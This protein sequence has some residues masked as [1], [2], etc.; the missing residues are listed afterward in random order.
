[1]LLPHIRFIQKIKKGL[2]LVSLSHFLH[3]F[4]MKIFLLLYSF[5][6]PSFIVLLLLLNEILG[7]M[8]IVIACSPGCHIIHFD[9]TLIFLIKPVFLDHRR[10]NTKKSIFSGR[11]ELLRWNKKHFSSFLKRLSL[12]HIKQFFFWKMR[13]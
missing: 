1:M 4:L 2:E 8:F 5:N 9:I 6:W 13:L 3:S 7:N 10:F 12:K 11:Q